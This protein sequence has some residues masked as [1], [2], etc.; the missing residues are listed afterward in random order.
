MLIAMGGFQ[1][2]LAAVCVPFVSAS[3][4]ACRGASAPVADS[5]SNG[6]AHTRPEA[7]QLKVGD[8]APEFSLPASDGRVYSL[9]SF[10]GKQAVVLAWFVKAFTAP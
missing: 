6:E 4:V 7:V 2:L 10:R 9:A 5:R 8:P 1:R 3:V